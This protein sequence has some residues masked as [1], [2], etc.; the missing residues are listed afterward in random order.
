MSLTLR[1]G[2]R[3]TKQTAESGIVVLL[4]PDPTERKRNSDQPPINDPREPRFDDG[5]ACQGDPATAGDKL[6]QGL[7]GHAI[8]L[9]LELSRN[10]GDD[11]V[12]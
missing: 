3:H 6:H 12:R 8:T 9:N 10:L 5:V 2:P 7:T 4:R 11:G 1:Q